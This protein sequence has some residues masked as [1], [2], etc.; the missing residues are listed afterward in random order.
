MMSRLSFLIVTATAFLAVAGCSKRVLVEIPPRMDLL[1]YDVV[2]VTTF[3]S[4]AEGNLASFATQRFIQTLQESQPGVR[5]LEL[6]SVPELARR[7]GNNAVDIDA[8]RK[9]GERYGVDVLIVGA[10]DVTDVRPKVDLNSV[11][12]TMSASAIVDASPTTRLVET[13]RG[14][15]LWTKSTRGT[16]T[17]AHVGISRGGSVRFDAQDPEKAY[18][19]LVDALIQDVTR[20]FR[21]TYARR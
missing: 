20:D 6:G 17:V 12:T 11:F 8:V 21:V 10:L 13:S 19:A 2:G 5:V 3:D 15:T 7:N 9:V 16:R 4:E 18:G 14:A 1:G